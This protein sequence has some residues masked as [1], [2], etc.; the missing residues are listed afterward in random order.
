MQL[1]TQAKPPLGV[2]FDCDLG[3]S[4]DD[5]IALAVLYALDG[6]DE[7][8]LLA[9][10]VSNPSLQAAAY[11]D[12]VGRFY[13]GAVSGAFNAIGRTLPV[14][15]SQVGKPMESPMITAPLGKKTPEGKPV[16]AHDINSI[17]DTADPTPLI[18]N[19]LTAQRDDN[20]VIILGGPATGLVSMMSLPGAKDLIT[21]KVKMLVF[22]GGGFPSGKADAHIQADVAAAKR[23]F[24]EWPT[25][26]VAVGAEVAEQLSFPIASLDTDFT[27][28]Q[29]H[30][31]VD[32]IRASGQT[33]DIP[34]LTP[35]AAL[36]AVRSE[37]GL[38]QRSAPGTIAVDDSGAVRFTAGAGGKHTYLSVDPAQREKVTKTIVELASAKPVVRAPRRR[39]GQAKPDPA[40]P[41]AAKPD[42]AKPDAA[43]PDAAKP[44]Q[45]GAPP[46]ATEPPKPAK[47]AAQPF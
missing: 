1:S 12:A 16:Y 42:A 36:F 11:S 26:I 32:A 6:K 37:Q 38:F 25:P 29:A 17:I 23:L 41:D 14:G 47:P 45:L 2:I 28:S 3:H 44:Q 22:A 20:I 18:R 30:P 8:R 21:R 34:V 15:L 33:K 40:K 10:S 39:P 46:A 13:A 24:A 7:A 31:V 5:V 27:W 19:A 4:V 9:V 35:S 43:K